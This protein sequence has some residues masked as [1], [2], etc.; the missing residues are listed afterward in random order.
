MGSKTANTA[1]KKEAGSMASEGL[2]LKRACVEWN[3][4]R[5]TERHRTMTATGRREGKDAPDI[6][7]ERVWGAHALEHSKVSTAYLQAVM[8]TSWG[9]V[10]NN[11]TTLQSAVSRN[12]ASNTAAYLQKC[13]SGEECP[14]VAPHLTAN[15]GERIVINPLL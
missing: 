6:D 1:Q 3:R 14:R 10:A 11:S 5:G 12:H 7:N 8:C 15:L 2:D 13:V 4:K 9:R